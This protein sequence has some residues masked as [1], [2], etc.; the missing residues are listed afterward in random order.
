MGAGY[1]VTRIEMK[2]VSRYNL[3]STKLLCLKSKP[4]IVATMAPMAHTTDALLGPGDDEQFLQKMAEHAGPSRGKPALDL[5]AK[6]LA[7]FMVKKRCG[8]NTTEI[9]LYSNG[10]MSLDEK[11]VRRILDLMSMQPSGGIQRADFFLPMMR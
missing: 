2:N 6:P 9:T 10:M 3:F 11:Q 7:S 5:K 4:S 8:L 1:D